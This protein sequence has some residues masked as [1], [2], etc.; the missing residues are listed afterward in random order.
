VVDAGSRH[1]SSASEDSG[2]TSRAAPLYSAQNRIVHGHAS[3]VA[4]ASE[5]AGSCSSSPPCR[6]VPKCIPIAVETFSNS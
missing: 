2:G 4:S 6:N 5:S 3:R 1:G